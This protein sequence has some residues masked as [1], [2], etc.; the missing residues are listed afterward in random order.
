MCPHSCIFVRNTGHQ[1]SLVLAYL[2]LECRGKTNTQ[3]GESGRAS[4]RTRPQSGGQRGETGCGQC[5]EGKVRLHWWQDPNERV[6]NGGES[7]PGGATQAAECL[8]A[9]LRERARWLGLAGPGLQS[10]CAGTAPRSEDPRPAGPPGPGGRLGIP[11]A[12]GSPLLPIPGRAAGIKQAA[13]PER[14]L[15]SG[16]QL[17]GIT[18]TEWFCLPAFSTVRRPRAM[19][20]R[21]GGGSGA[22]RGGG[23]DPARSPTHATPPPPPPRPQPGLPGPPEPAPSSARR[24]TGGRDGRG[25]GGRGEGLKMQKIKVFAGQAGSESRAGG[26]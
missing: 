1:D 24:R 20:Q 10:P 3:A 11:G 8:S 26:E 12:A 17:L 23:A 19:D 21:R 18:L 16:R 22:G 13:E 9:S 7:P 2:Q 4:G 15:I 14:V 6:G 25:M 5:M